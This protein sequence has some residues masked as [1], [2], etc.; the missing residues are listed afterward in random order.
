M[1]KIIQPQIKPVATS[2]V[3]TQAAAV[4]VPQ[5]PTAEQILKKKVQEL[6]AQLAKMQDE[7]EEAKQAGWD[8]GMKL[9]LEQAERESSKQIEIYKKELEDK[10]HEA[11]SV[12]S[13]Q[14]YD[15]MQSLIAE[16]ESL[17]AAIVFEVVAK[18]LG[19]RFKDEAL[20]RA[21]IEQSMGTWKQSGP[22]KIKVN[23]DWLSVL[24]DSGALD[25]AQ[26]TGIEYCVDESVEYGGCIVTSETHGIFDARIDVM[27]NDVLTT[28]RHGATQ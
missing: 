6:E 15:G 5:P 9:G 18:L 20:I 24:R 25:R 26:A 16:K 12:L 4:V 22:L 13:D 3:S 23:S 8:Q 27:L 28:L 14:I 17:S 21:Y 11:F 10:F 7:Q 2:T 1:A 19:K